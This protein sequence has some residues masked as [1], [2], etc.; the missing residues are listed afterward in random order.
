MNEKEREREKKNSKRKQLKLDQTI[1]FVW[2]IAGICF[3]VIVVFSP[4]SSFLV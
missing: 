3:D 2:R 4:S 1:I